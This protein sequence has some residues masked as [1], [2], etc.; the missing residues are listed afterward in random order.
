MPEYTF[1]VGST[2]RWHGHWRLWTT[3]AIE[4]GDVVKL[5]GVWAGQ[6]EATGAY[7]LSLDSDAIAQR[8]AYGMAVETGNDSVLCVRGLDNFERELSLKSV[9]RYV[10]TMRHD[11]TDGNRTLYETPDDGALTIP[12]DGA[13]G[14]EFVHD[15]RG[16]YVAYLVNSDA[17]VAA[18]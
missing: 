11:I 13:L 3:G 14:W 15:I 16:E 9:A 2:D 18:L 8:V 5:C 7:T 4:H 10:V 1:Y 6:R 17:T 12:D